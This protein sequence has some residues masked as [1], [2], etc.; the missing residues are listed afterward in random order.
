MNEAG[1]VVEIMWLDETRYPAAEGQPGLGSLEWVQYQLDNFATV[2]EVVRHASGLRIASDAKLHYLICERSGRCAS[3]EF[4]GGRLVAHT[5]DRLP[6]AALANSPYDES[7]RFLEKGGTGNGIGGSGSNARFARAAKRIREYRSGD[8]VEHAFQTLGSVGQSHTQWSIVYD[9]GARRVYWQT[10]ANPK[11][12]WADLGTFDLSCSSPVV[13]L[14]IDQGGGAM[15]RRFS[16]YRAAANR[17]LV[18]RSFRGT[19][20]LSGVPT[21]EMEAVARQPERTVCSLPR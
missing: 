13:T 7:L 5:G 20:F 21:A 2:D 3:I 6:V 18:T 16:P 19:P 10:A 8:P 1:L 12:R 11:R 14:D 15:T 17:E 4:L 9:M